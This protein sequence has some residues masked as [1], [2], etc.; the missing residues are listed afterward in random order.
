MAP[1]VQ[2]SP[3]GCNYAGLFFSCVY[4]LYWAVRAA[5]APGIGGAFQPV[6]SKLSA[7][8]HRL[9]LITLQGHEEGRREM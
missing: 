8:S 9:S 1:K 6:I 5:T 3:E 7:E 4:A 2:P